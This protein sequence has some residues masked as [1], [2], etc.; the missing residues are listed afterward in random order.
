MVS[1]PPKYLFCEENVNLEFV[2]KIVFTYSITIPSQE[3]TH[4]SVSLQITLI[5]LLEVVHPVVW[6]FK[7]WAAPHCRNQVATSGGFDQ[8]HQ[9]IAE[10]VQ[11]KVW[12][13]ASVWV[14][15]A[16]FLRNLNHSVVEVIISVKGF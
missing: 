11:G 1:T 7:F 13:L 8:N 15:I 12:P 3:C 16:Q 4:F 6:C 10:L 14:Q 5:T 9:D 2:L